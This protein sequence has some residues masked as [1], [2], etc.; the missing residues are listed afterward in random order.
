VNRVIDGVF[1]LG[2]NWAISNDAE[3]PADDRRRGKN[4]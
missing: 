3:K 4:R 2:G 1:K